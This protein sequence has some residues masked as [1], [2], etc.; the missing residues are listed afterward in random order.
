MSYSRENYRKIKEEFSQKR[1]NALAGAEHRLSELEKKYPELK[2]LN[3]VIS[4]TG[5]RI[6]DAV[7]IKDGK[8]VEEKLR[9]IEAEH[10]ANVGFRKQFLETYGYPS[11]YLDIHYDCA[12]CSDEGYDDSGKMCICMK[13]ALALATYESSGIGKLITKQNFDNFSFKYYAPGRERENI[14]DIFDYCRE[15]ADTFSAKIS[16]NMLFCGT[17]GLGKT[18]LSTSVAKAVIDRG[19]DVV[20]VTAQKLFD[21]F[22]SE[23]FSRNYSDT[24]G[25]L[26]DKYFD[27]DL[28]IIDDLGTEMSTQFT[29]SC[30]YNLVNT[31]INTEKPMIINTNLEKEKMREKYADRITSRLFGEFSVMQFIGRDIRAQKLD[32]E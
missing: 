22:E 26:T 14:N 4:Q 10:D 19:F 25:E 30:L 9:E 2:E 6:M 13:R 32:E 31:R 16:E 3:R 21:D 28:L 11:D 24:R 18:H 29:V 17:T 1:A 23:K 27:C 15:Y 8:S 5:A 7:L 20:Y 12:L